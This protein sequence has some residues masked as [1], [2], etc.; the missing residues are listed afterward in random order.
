MKEVEMDNLKICPYCGEEILES[1]I[2]CKYCGEVLNKESTNGS[3]RIEIPYEYLNTIK[4][5][6]TVLSII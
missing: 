2:K 6:I 4:I 1:A 3:K 5:I